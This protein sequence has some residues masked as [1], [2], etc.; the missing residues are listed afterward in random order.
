M[1][2]FYMQIITPDIA[3]ARLGLKQGEE[4]KQQ[5]EEARKELE[6]LLQSGGTDDQILEKSRKVD[7]MIDHFYRST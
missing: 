7:E 3:A 6:K 2:R 1:R 4:L 5:I